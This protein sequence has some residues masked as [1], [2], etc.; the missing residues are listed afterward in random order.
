[1]RGYIDNCLGFKNKYKTN[2]DISKKHFFL[3]RIDHLVYSNQKQQQFIK[4]LSALLKKAQ[5]PIKVTPVDGTSSAVMS[6]WWVKYDHLNEKM[7]TSATC[8][9]SFREKL[10]SNLLK[11]KTF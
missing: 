4:I 8:N 7:Y 2:S 1:M 10:C 11:L 9:L 3:L 6:S 5:K